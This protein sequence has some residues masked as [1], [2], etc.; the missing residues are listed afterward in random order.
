ML[1]DFEQF[2]ADLGSDAAR[3]T[4]AELRQL[5]VEVYR[6]AELLIE[7]HRS[8]QQAKK[9][10]RSPQVVVDA[11]IGDRT[12]E[13]SAQCLTPPDDAPTSSADPP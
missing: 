9:K 12:I 2:V 5:H 10:R 4:P 6:M 11:G 13:S 1:D 3:Y 8:R 7:I